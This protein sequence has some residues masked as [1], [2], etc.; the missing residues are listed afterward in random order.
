MWKPK[1]TRFCLQ[2]V[3][4]P[5]ST[6]E[7]N[8][9]NDSIL[10]AFEYH[11]PNVL[12]EAA[13]RFLLNPGSDPILGVVKHKKILTQMK[14]GHRHNCSLNAVSLDIFKHKKHIFL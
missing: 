5:L 6:R 3:Y 14:L 8:L 4:I 2:N 12:Q 11:V 9:I 1:F 10:C 13:A 7:L